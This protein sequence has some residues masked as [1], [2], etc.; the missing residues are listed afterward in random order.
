V[1]APKLR[2]AVT[3]GSGE[4]GTLVL[5]RLLADRSI[6][7]V[8]SLD[9]RPPIVV[10]PRLEAVHADIREPNFERRFENCDAVIHLAFVVV[11][12]RPR[13]EFDAINVEGS[14]NVFRA[15][16]RAGVKQIV[17]TSS[18]AA[19][20]VVPGHP[21][22][23]VEESPRRHQPEF[24]YSSAKWQV[25][26]FLDGFEREHS[27][28]AIA[29]LRPGILLGTRME[30]AL[31]M[32]LSR[33]VVPDMG[34]TPL[35][36][37]WDEDVADAVM[38]C[39][40]SGARGAFNLC[41]A[42]PQPTAKLAAELGVR[43]M[44]L[45]KTLLRAAAKLSPLAS[46][47]GLG[48]STDPAWVEIDGAVMVPSAEKARRELGWK[49]KCDRVA[50]VLRRYFEA[51]PGKLDR[52]IDV[53]LRLLQFASRYAEV[54]EEAKRI[55]MVMHLELTG[56]G[57]GD[58]GLH[59]DLGKLSVERLA[60]RPPTATVTMRASTFLD[61]IAG[62]QVFATALLTGKVRVDGEATAGMLLEGIV[63]SFRARARQPGA[64]AFPAR[65]L[66]RWFKNSNGGSKIGPRSQP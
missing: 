4:L 11:G 57:G 31:G 63:A 29:R 42:D 16:A 17:Y 55:R 8:I 50:D 62:R 35:P 15:A 1:T 53:F 34:A 46:R 2:V 18:V 9:V 14:K 54:P 23:I 7:E 52:R 65:Q 64:A 27:Q 26:Q 48:P 3:G 19:Y 10:S 39:L 36:L 12:W 13:A 24:P 49:P 37:V 22:P 45:P 41:A 32:A 25:E 51:A 30:H 43:S 38:L 20:G 44:R 59:F 47:I 60:P 6:G 66:E 21:V 56:P 33:G 5:K 58:I 40:K 61:L 28:L